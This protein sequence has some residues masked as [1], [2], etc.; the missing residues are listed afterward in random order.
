MNYMALGTELRPAAKSHSPETQ[1]RK[2]K[3]ATRYIY[4]VAGPGQY[5]SSGSVI[6]LERNPLTRIMPTHDKYR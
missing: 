1:T 4:F 2:L 6:S 3:R 5:N